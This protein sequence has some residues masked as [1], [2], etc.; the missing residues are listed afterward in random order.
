MDNDFKIGDIVALHKHKV[1]TS[2]EAIKVKGDY[3]YG[4]VVFVDQVES[5]YSGLPYLVKFDFLDERVDTGGNVITH[6][7]LKR[8]W[9]FYRSGSS[10]PKKLGKGYF[11]WVGNRHIDSDSLTYNL[12]LIN[13]E[14]NEN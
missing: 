5:P 11:C 6:Q 7:E 12:I 8:D 14:L 4:K 2:D 3:V 10:F 9:E 13:R 1:M